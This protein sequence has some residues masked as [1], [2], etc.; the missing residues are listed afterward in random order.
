M[1]SSFLFLLAILFSSAISLH[2]KD[3]S[4]IEK[5]PQRLARVTAESEKGWKSGVTATMKNASYAYN[6][7]LAAMIKDLLGAYYPKE[8]RTQEDIDEYLKALYTMHHFQQDL[9]NVSGEAP[10]TEAGLEVVGDVS[11]DL[12][13]TVA[14]M[15]EAIVKD[16][17]KF[18]FKAWKKKWQ[19]SHK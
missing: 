4:V 1:K 2:A 16:E 12:E 17:P 11:A 14:S 9:A 18:N 5:L 10:G 6:N 15:V 8:Y 3:F 7:T 13:A 19:Q